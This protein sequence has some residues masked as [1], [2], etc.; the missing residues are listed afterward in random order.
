MRRRDRPWGREFQGRHGSRTR[1]VVAHDGIPFTTVSRKRERSLA[2]VE[3][4]RAELRR[5]C[6]R[7]TGSVIE[8]E[9]IVQETLARA[10]IR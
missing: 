3:G 5:Y 9:D 4:I 2:T 6:A 10:F 8:G 1:S 7:V